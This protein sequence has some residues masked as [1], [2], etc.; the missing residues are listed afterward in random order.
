MVCLS[1]CVCV[2][3]CVNVCLSVLNTLASNIYLLYGDILAI[4][5]F[6]NQGHWF[7]VKIIF[8]KWVGVGGFRTAIT[9]VLI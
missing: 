7:K 3:V 1:V 6:D 9:N 5:R 4:S 8:V 2:C